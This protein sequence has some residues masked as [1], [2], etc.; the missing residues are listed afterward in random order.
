MFFTHPVLSRWFCKDRRYEIRRKA[1]GSKRTHSSILATCQWSK[2]YN[3]H[4]VDLECVLTYCDNATDSP[5]TPHNYAFEWDGEVVKLGESMEYPCKDDMAIENSTSWK[6]NASTSASVLCGPEGYLIYPDPWPQ[7]S[8][9]V[10]CEVPANLNIPDDIY[11]T[12][13][14][15]TVYYTNLVR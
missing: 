9:T 12:Y 15:D 10:Q 8:D 11:T 4:P 6:H 7:C 2:L 3:F 1:A 5:N 13:T 14:Q